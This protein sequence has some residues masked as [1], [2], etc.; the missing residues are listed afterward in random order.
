MEHE[1]FAEYRSRLSWYKTLGLFAGRAL[2]DSR[3]IDV[4]LNRIFLKLIL[5]RPV[6]RTIGN[7]K[8]VDI[9]LARSLERLQTYLQ[10]RKEIEALK[11]PPGARRNKLMQLTV[12]GAKLG[13]L[14]L[15]FT[16]PGYDIELKP[17]GSHIDVDDSNLEEYL[18]RVLDFTLGEGIKKQVKSFQE[19]FSMIFSI[20]DLKIFSPDELGLLFGN[21]DEDW[22]KDSEFH[23]RIRNQLT[24]ALEHIIKADHGYNLDS[25]SVQNLIEVMTNYSKDERR[26]FLQ[27]LVST[28]E[29]GRD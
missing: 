6:K 8:L 27:L 4:N 9:T 10:T 29:A 28:S 14:S 22:S 2:L 11:L 5:G 7:L 12:S 1:G 23:S 25:R 13:D 20:D 3:I 24:L 26:Q 18:E 21:A 17:G 15:D 19:G 16:L